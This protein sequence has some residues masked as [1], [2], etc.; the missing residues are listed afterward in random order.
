MRGRREERERGRKGGRRR[1][2]KKG[3]IGREEG[4]GGGEGEGEIYDCA[5][6]SSKY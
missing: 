2:R 6:Q 5:I 1:E 4:R 3:I